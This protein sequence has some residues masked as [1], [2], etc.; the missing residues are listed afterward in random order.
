MLLVV[1]GG[2]RHPVCGITFVLS[3]VKA[4]GSKIGMKMGLGGHGVAVKHAETHTDSI[5]DL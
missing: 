3:Y 5:G 1:I 4:S 2:N